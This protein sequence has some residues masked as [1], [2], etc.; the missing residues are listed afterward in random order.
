MA[1]RPQTPGKALGGGTSCFQPDG[2]YTKNGCDA[3]RLAA[4]KLA[5]AISKIAGL[6]ADRNAWRK[7]FPTLKGEKRKDKAVQ[8]VEAENSLKLYRDERVMY[9][10][11][12][13]RIIAGLDEGRFNVDMKPAEIVDDARE[14]GGPS[15][16]DEEDDE[17]EEG[18]SDQPPLSFTGHGAASCGDGWQENWRA[19]PQIFG[20]REWPVVY[21]HVT[22][23]HDLKLGTLL[24]GTPA[25]LAK[26]IA[27]MFKKLK[28]T[29]D[30]MEILPHA[31][32]W[33]LD[34]LRELLAR[35][36]MCELRGKG[37][38]ASEK[39][40]AEMFEDL[41]V[42]FDADP[43]AFLHLAGGKNSLLE[44]TI[45]RSGKKAAAV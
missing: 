34:A 30:R 21:N 38:A 39:A 18:G 20:E 10:G 22:K 26:Y 16:D 4:K 15:S 33:F 29:K 7:E 42:A 14:G 1:K 13:G 36:A 40:A 12:L 31:P 2:T 19:Y 11:T 3:L 6:T 43:D 35:H 27:G 5:A 45:N 9:G 37:E 25:A 17:E 23:L 8:I 24:V 32:E 28:T 41:M 44:M